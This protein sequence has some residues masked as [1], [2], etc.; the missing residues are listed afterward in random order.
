MSGET[1]GKLTI[2]DIARL[3]G[4]SK[5]TVSRVLNRNP[6]VDPVLAQ[7][8]MKVV[9]EHNFVPNITATVLAGGRT[10]LIG[11]LAPPLNWPAIPEIMR[12]VAEYLEGSPY[13]IVLYCIGSQRNHADVLNRILAMRMIS[14][15]LAIFPGGL[16]RQLPVHFQQGLPLVMIDDQEEPEG[17]PWV[18]VDN[19][20]SAYKATQY[21]LACGHTRI[22]HI[23]GPLSYHCTVERY[24]GYC[25]ALREAGITP[26][27]D[28]L[29]QSNFE[30]SGGRHCA[31]VLFARERDR[32][33][34][35]LFIGNDEMAY[36][37]LEVAQE[38][39][40]RIPED[41]AVVGFDDYII[42]AHTN[43][44]LTTVHQ[45]FSDIGRTAIDLLLSMI[46]HMSEKQPTRD[47]RQTSGG[48]PTQD[49]RMDPPCIHLPTTLVQRA[50]SRSVLPAS[51]QP[52]SNS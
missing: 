30:Q 10:Q 47:G 12:G 45:P 5:A 41:I 15:L 21:L 9:Q 38:L 48:V 26:D 34:T 32:W 7:R 20:T 33:P 27:P 24:Q 18:G 36:G 51:R 19:L 43:P 35:A 8:V 6:S 44:P 29:F 2:L 37:F 49:Y 1:Q 16:A 14:G 13:E 46:D 11:V 50:S 42:S 31:S 17:V 28:L 25:Q 22:A 23:Q 4:V 52:G 39:G 40:V 3:A